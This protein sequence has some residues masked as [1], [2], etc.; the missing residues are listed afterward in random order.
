MNLHLDKLKGIDPISVVKTL[1]NKAVD[2]INSIKAQLEHA[3]EVKLTRKL[4]LAGLNELI[5]METAP[6]EGVNPDPA[7][8]EVYSQAKMAIEG[9]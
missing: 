7:A 8:V 5:G 4:V 1:D 2:E 6:P 3:I 9:L